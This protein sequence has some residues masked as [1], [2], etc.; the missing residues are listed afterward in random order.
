MNDVKKL[1]QE[2]SQIFKDMYDNK[3][4]KRVPINVS[5]EYGI[6]AKHANI[7]LTEVQWQPHIL[8]DAADKLCQSV[9]SD[10]L[11]YVAPFRFPGTYEIL[12]SKPFVLAD[13]GFLQHPEI[14]GMLSEEYDDLIAKPLDC[15]YEKVIPRFYPGLSLDDPVNMTLN[16]ERSMS[17]NDNEMMKMVGF[18]QTLIEKYGY[19]ASNFLEGGLSEAPMDFVADL[20][21]GFKGMSM[22]LR[23]RPDKVAE[24]AEAVYPIVKNKGMPAIP[25]PYGRVVFPIHMPAFMREKDFEKY[26]WPSFKKLADDY[27]SMGINVY[28]FCENDMMRYLDYLYELPTNTVLRFEYGDAKIVKEKLGKKHILTGFV[29][30]TYLK[31]HTKQECIDMTKEYLDILAPGGKYYFEFDKVPI[32]PSDINLENMIAVTE[33]VRDYGI[34]SNPGETAG[35]G[36]NKNDYTAKP[37]RTIES[38][39]FKTWDQY[40]TEN[41]KLSKFAKTQLQEIE[42]KLFTF[43]AGLLM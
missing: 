3:I 16:L 36:F 12:K 29:P 17:L 7:N 8:H 24:A 39:Y 32:S 31:T 42:E 23:R 34:Y 2:R 4:P 20:L 37:S 1:Q 10:I 11:V 9:Y 43:M 28:L 41:P 6:V 25:S 38:K 35:L 19:Y 33:T 21:R 26:W 18:N 27:A 13:D 22:D 40:R 30:L 5:L 15:L 14:E